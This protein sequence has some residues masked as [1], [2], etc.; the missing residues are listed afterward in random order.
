MEGRLSDIDLYSL[1]QTLSLAQRTGELYVD[2]EAGNV[3]LLFIYHG[4]LLYIADRH[5]RSLERLQDLL[6]GQTIDWPNLNEEHPLVETH[7]GSGWAEYECFWWLL[8]HRPL[9][10]IQTLWRAV[11]REALFDVATLYRGWFCFRLTAALAPQLSSLPLTSLL[12]ETLVQL[13]EWKKLYPYIRSPDQQLDLANAKELHRILPESRLKHLETWAGEHLSLRRLSRRLGRDLTS[14]GK[15]LSPYLQQ[16][17][18]EL[19]SPLPSGYLMPLS[20]I[21]LRETPRIVCIDDAATVRQVVELAL[22]SAGYEATAIAHPLKALSLIF[23]LNPDLIL[24]DIAMPEL[25]GYDFCTMLRHTPRFRY[26]PIIML[27]S[28]VGLPDRLR[29]N[30]AG[31]TDYL[32][33]PFTSTELLTMTRRYIGCANPA[34]GNSDE[35]FNDVL[36]QKT[37]GEQAAGS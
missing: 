3:W 33:K 28:L 4:R 36:E 12:S 9:T 7:A 31:A 25:D 21:S 1:F 10:Q 14:V 20:P 34:H 2:D 37:L 30:I 27:T 24:C 32:S 29:A 11:I 23:Q 13:R 18:L 19:N 5:S 35:I 26:T 8:G 17:L 6:Y 22:K 15:V 16:G